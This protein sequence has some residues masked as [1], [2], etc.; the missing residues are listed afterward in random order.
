MGLAG[1]L[2]GMGFVGF[3]RWVFAD[4]RILDRDK[5]GLVAAAAPWRVC[6]LDDLWVMGWC[7][8]C[9]YWAVG[10]GR[11]VF[12]PL[13]LNC[14]NVNMEYGSI[15]EILSWRALPIRP[16]CISMSISL[17]SFS[18][19]SFSI[20]TI[21]RRSH[22]RFCIFFYFFFNWHLQPSRDIYLFISFISPLGIVIRVKFPCGFY[23]QEKSVREDW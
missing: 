2:L 7:L 15:S 23:F 5:G 21:N 13:F 1:E 4:W 16:V 14:M 11:R 10:G 12:R 8:I 20:G 22:V 6:D 19:H 17:V 9:T 3:L 18:D